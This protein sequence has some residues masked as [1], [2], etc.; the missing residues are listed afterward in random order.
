MISLRT[1]LTILPLILITGAGV[2]QMSQS[3]I[4]DFVTQTHQEIPNCC[5]HADNELTQLAN[6]V[7]LE[8][9][10]YPVST[11]HFEAFDQYQTKLLDTLLS[12]L[13]PTP[14]Y[15]FSIR[16][17]MIKDCYDK[18]Y[19]KWVPRLHE[20]GTRYYI[21]LYD[22]IRIN[23]ESAVRIADAVKSLV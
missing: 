2:L 5:T 23:R 22:N 1:F 7:E 16:G 20:Y 19:S 21:A 12:L 15:P 9:T 10:L 11:S 17:P 6:N 4:Q 14:R 8:Q 13:D 3:L 18:L